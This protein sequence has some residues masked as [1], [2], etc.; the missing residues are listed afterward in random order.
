MSRATQQNASSPS[1][2]P[3][4]IHR[5]QALSFRSTPLLF[6]AICFAA[7]IIGDSLLTR[8]QTPALR[9]VC[10]VFLMIV[11]WLSQCIA[12][13]LQLLA[14]STVWISLGW[15]CAGL[16]QHASLRAP[17]TA[18][19]DA[20]VRDVEGRV[21]DV[22]SL[23]TPQTEDADTSPSE[24]EEQA[25]NKEHTWVID[26][27]A[28]RVED[29]TP[30]LS[31]MVSTSGGIRLLF[32]SEQEPQIKCGSILHIPMRLRPPSHYQN[33]GGWRYDAWLAEQGIAV[34]ATT[35]VRALQ[36]IGKATP[37]LQCRIRALQH[38]A[39]I[40]LQKATDIPL[41]RH[42]PHRLRMTSS[43]AALFGAMLLGDRTGLF[44]SER[45]QLERTGS[46]HLVVV[47]GMH[48]GL[49]AAMLLWICTQLRAGRIPSTLLSLA[50]TT[51]YAMLTGFGAPVQ[52][53]LF[54]TAAYLLARMLARRSSSLN[55]LGCAAL[56][57]LVL[58][59]SSLF[60]ASFQM[61][62]LAVIAIAGIALPFGERTFLP[63]AR[64]AKDIHLLR[65]DAHLHPRL[66][67]FR[68][69]LRLFASLIAP[70]HA[71]QATTILASAVRLLLWAL[72]LAWMSIISEIL[73]SLPMMLYFHRLT[74]AA[75]PANLI[76]VP[77]IAPL[78]IAAALFL[79]AACISTGVA[80]IFSIP[81]A[82]LLHL[83]FAV[84]HYFG[85]LRFAEMRTP[86]PTPLQIAVVL[87]LWLAAVWLVRRKQRS[88]LLAG[89]ATVLP[90]AILLI[91]PRP[92]C[93]LDKLEVTALDVGQGDSIFVVAPDGAA[94]LVDAGGPTGSTTL[95]SRDNFDIGEEV[96]SPYL[97]QRR[98]RRIDVAV[99]THAHSDH[100]GGM[101]AII[102]NFHPRELWL[103]VT[104]PS[105]MLENILRLARENN[106]RIQ[107]LRDGSTLNWHNVAVQALAPATTYT[108][109]TPAN[110]DSLV[111][112]LQ[113]QHASALLEGDAEAASEAIMLSHH[114]EELGS[115]L[116]KI[117]HHGSR[118]STT[119][120]F[121][122]AVHPKDAVISDGRYNTFG[123]PRPEVLE[124]LA[125]EHVH[126]YRTDT[127][128]ATTFL[129]STNGSVTASRAP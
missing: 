128:G 25:A 98:F 94:M 12:P 41:L 101:A 63:Y 115:D 78:M 37:D 123:H 80:A 45:I 56:A 15:T 20:L 43:D 55:P 126:T 88:I 50:G 67:Q 85:N 22:R 103:S 10:T 65:L 70:S 46:F 102:R 29:M 97:W 35:R 116:L 42:L 13:R 73:M 4:P 91:P 7:G 26:L 32:A 106:V 86:A 57:M 39:T 64:A 84:L 16:Q 104:P 18:Y 30:D 53:A 112:H 6:A 90:L 114:K 36:I 9:C 105:A 52:R 21:L 82:V 79:C 117:A 27:A 54:M 111:L 87:L 113:W 121:L 120:A 58:S 51:C 125:S 60:E 8:W 68:V 92:S 49:V 62:V 89:M 1:G 93:S 127:L 83:V 119:E 107:V 5:L 108:S 14:L 31:Q 17:I 95:S 44:H 122:R 110:N 77:L 40:H 28:T 124:R 61:T 72:E 76:A 19:S 38:W 75:L 47:A 66:A 71:K 2:H 109:H 48:I 81:A 11:A 24:A 3:A 23:T 99:I 96:V 59:P 129:L 69:A 33:P 100:I 74:P 118:T 34:R